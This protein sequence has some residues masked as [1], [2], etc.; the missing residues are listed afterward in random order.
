MNCMALK[1]AD[2]QVQASVPST[3]KKRKRIKRMQVGRTSGLTACE[4]EEEKT[5]TK[6]KSR[7]KT[8]PW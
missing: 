2:A 8:C 3:A 1:E 4:Q 7:K 5:T 6:Q